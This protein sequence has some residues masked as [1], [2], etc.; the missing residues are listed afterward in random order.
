MHGRRTA[1]RYS[2]STPSPAGVRPRGRSTV[3]PFGRAGG[4]LHRRLACRWR[5]VGRRSMQLG[6]RSE[7]PDTRILLLLRHGKTS[8]A[9]LDPTHC[10]C[11]WLWP[12]AC[13]RSHTECI[14]SMVLYSRSAR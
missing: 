8:Y 12:V 5:C 6:L 3:L 7:S 13:G 14:L 4:S 9:L 11:A 2:P 1:L 10:V